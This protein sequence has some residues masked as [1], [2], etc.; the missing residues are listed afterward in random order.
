MTTYALEVNH[1]DFIARYCEI[2]PHTEVEVGDDVVEGQVIAYVGDQPGQDMLHLE[3]FSGRLNGDL[4][5]TPGT[6]PPYD[7]RDD[8][9]DGTGYLDQAVHTVT[10]SDDD[11][12]YRYDVDEKGRKFVQKPDLRDI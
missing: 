11:N 10:H 9:F 1:P 3:F 5:S 8:V 4:S 2:D 6:H 12:T 7:R